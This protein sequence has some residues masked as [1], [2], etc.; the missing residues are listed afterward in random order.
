MYSS[1]LKCSGVPLPLYLGVGAVLVIVW[2]WLIWFSGH[3]PT[4]GGA[5]YAWGGLLIVCK[6]I[7]ALAPIAL[8]YFAWDDFEDPAGEIFYPALVVFVGVLF[9]MWWLTTYSDP[10]ALPFDFDHIGEPGYVRS[11]RETEAE[12]VNTLLWLAGFIGVSVACAWAAK[13]R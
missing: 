5:V 10:T 7:G 3:A 12:L 11:I 1:G 2:E 6:I 8:V 4:V 13:E 9:A